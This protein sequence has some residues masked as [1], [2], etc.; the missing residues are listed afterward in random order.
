MVLQSSVHRFS[1]TFTTETPGHE[2]DVDRELGIV[3]Q[4]TGSVDTGISELPTKRRSEGTYFFLPVL[5]FPVVT[6]ER[7]SS[8]FFQRSWGGPSESECTGPVLVV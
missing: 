8:L 7:N 1:T 5:Y 6:S 2:R 3:E 4:G